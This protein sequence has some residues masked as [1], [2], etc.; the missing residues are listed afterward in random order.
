MTDPSAPHHGYWDSFY[1]SRVSSEVPDAPSS[2]AEWAAAR[3][4]TGRTIAEFGFGTGRDALW[5]AG[6][7][8][9]VVG[10]EF[11][12]S[13]VR[14]AQSRADGAGFDTEF[15]E[16]DL[17][18]RSATQRVGEA[19]SSRGRTTI[20]GR[21]LIHSLEDEGRHNL[22]D[23]AAVALREGGELYLEFRTGQDQGAEHLF[24]DDHFRRYLDP[25]TV[26]RELVD[27]GAVIVHSES[28]HGLAVYKS[29]DP[30]V[31]RVVAGW[32]LDA[33]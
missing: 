24:G 27:R 11:A 3:I 10:Y 30:H 28:S 26:E 7:G 29:E 12:G 16:L 15:V 33:A 17:Y 19:L 4:G 13:A 14:S 2:F 22:F 6:Q 9:G 23:L 18:D 1:D 31:A 8:R 25:A 21:F 20:Y 32:S 5:F